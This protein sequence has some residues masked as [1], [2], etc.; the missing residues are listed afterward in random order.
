MTRG[1]APSVKR[2]VQFSL[3]PDDI[4]FQII[5]QGWRPRQEIIKIRIVSKFWSLGYFFHYIRQIIIWAKAVEDRRFRNAVNNCT[6]ISSF[7]TFGK[8]PVASP[9]RKIF[10]VS[11]TVV[12][13]DGKMSILKIPSEIFLLVQGIQDRF[14]YPGRTVHICRKCMKPCKISI[15]CSMLPAGMMFCRE[16]KNLLFAAFDISAYRYRFEINFP[17]GTQ[18]LEAVPS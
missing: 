5:W 12:I 1:T 14:P 13:V 11:F 2:R 3:F 10:Y 8:K 16:S 7:D 15:N 6:G 17:I 4:G 9:N 18:R